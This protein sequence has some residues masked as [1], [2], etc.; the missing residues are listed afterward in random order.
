MMYNVALAMICLLGKQMKR[1]YSVSFP[2]DERIFC[3]LTVILIF[4]LLHRVV[5]YIYSWVIHH[6]A[7]GSFSPFLFLPTIFLI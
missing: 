2:E 7:M 1:G 3:L 4:S 5:D 6:D